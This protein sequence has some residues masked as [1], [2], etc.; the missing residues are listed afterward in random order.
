MN[1]SPNPV[2]TRHCSTDSGLAARAHHDDLI[3]ASLIVAGCLNASVRHRPLRLPA[4]VADPT[5]RRFDGPLSVNAKRI[6]YRLG[7]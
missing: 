5:H 2:S 6:P 1:D 3:G 7:G 4:E